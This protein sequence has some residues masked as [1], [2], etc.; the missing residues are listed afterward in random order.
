[1]KRDRNKLRT[2]TSTEAIFE[3]WYSETLPQFPKL[4][5]NHIQVRAKFDGKLR[6]FNL[7]QQAN[8][9]TTEEKIKLQKIV[10]N[11]TRGDKITY[12]TGIYDDKK[13]ISNPTNSFF[14]IERR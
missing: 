10:E 9:M 14:K 6:F 11:L 1:M 2:E 12:W 5:Q 7:I 3:L 4:D 13:D 8:L